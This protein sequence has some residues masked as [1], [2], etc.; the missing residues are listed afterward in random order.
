MGGV[1]DEVRLEHGCFFEHGLA[2][3]GR[4]IVC[5]GVAKLLGKQ[6]IHKSK[7]N[8]ERPV[9]IGRPLLDVEDGLADCLEDLWYNR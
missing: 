1:Y 9:L 3:I 4:M 8:V 7:I 2:R 6:I 5:D